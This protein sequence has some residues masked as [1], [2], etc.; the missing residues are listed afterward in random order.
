MPSHTMRKNAKKSH[1]CKSCGVEFMPAKKANVFCSLACAIKGKKT[2]QKPEGILNCTMCL[3]NAGVGIKRIPKLIPTVSLNWIFRGWKRTGFQPITSTH[4]AGIRSENS[5]E[6]K[7]RIRA[8]IQQR[9]A[10]RDSSRKLPKG[11]SSMD[12]Y[13]ANHEE[14]KRACRE[15][16]AKRYNQTKHTPQHKIHQLIRNTTGRIARITNGRNKKEKRSHEILGCS[17]DE[18]RAHIERQ[19]QPGMTWENYGQ[20]VIDHIFPISKVDLMNVN[21]VQ[22]VCRY[23][24]LQPL[25]KKD[26]AIKGDKIISHQAALL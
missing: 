8:D 14:R 13:Y 7:S 11:A 16:A 20:W 25:W 24:N 19:F 1:C 17:F 21:Q 22:I 6:R 3:R 2:R 10:I 15:R 26:N 18:A 4:R 5:R 9:Q 23:T 12:Y